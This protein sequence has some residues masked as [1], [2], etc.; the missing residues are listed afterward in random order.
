[1]RV[2]LAGAGGAIGRRLIPQL[3]AHGHD[4]VASTRDAAKLGELE[5]LGARGVV[6]DGLDAG[7][8]GDA[9]AW[10]EPEAVVHQMTALSAMADLKHF[11]DEFAR[12][13]ELRTRG[14]DN[15]LAAAK[16]VGVRRF[17]AQSFGGWPGI[18]S[19]GPVKTET[20]PLDPEP[21][22]AQQKTLAAIRYVERAVV[23]AAPIEGL[24]LRYGAFYGPGSSLSTEY[25]ELV[26]KRKLPI[27]G[28]G[29]GVWSF[30]HLDDAASA[31]VAALERGAPG[32]YNVVDDEPAA[33]R[34]WLPYFA[35]C[36]GA[37][38]PRHIPVWLARLAVGEVGVSMMTQI[39]GCSNAKAKRELA[40]RPRYASWRDGFRETADTAA[41][42]GEPGAQRAAA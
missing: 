30:I 12:T 37:R 33:V 41:R 39:R 23:E 31:T 14:T 20:D 26:R 36:V 13:N 18:R 16:A 1:M 42:S 8:V 10:A 15:L 21:P 11:D 7:S 3:V 5:A 38:P 19:G 17:V 6:M 32:V 22:A 40:W 25:P 24:A 29:G 9:F 28:D 34:E 4:V 27:V 2:F 35:E